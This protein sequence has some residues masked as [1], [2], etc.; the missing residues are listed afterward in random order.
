MPAAGTQEQLREAFARWGL[1]RRMRVDNGTPWG[2]T[3]ELPTE[4]ALWLIGLGVEMIWNPPR[5]PQ[6]NGVVERSQGTGKRWAEP[7]TCR[8]VAELRLRLEEQDDIQRALYPR[9]K[10]LSRMEA[11]PGLKH[12]GRAYRPD[13]EERA[14]D[15]E[16]VLSHLADYVLVRRVD[17]SGTVSVY[18]KSRYVGKALCGRDVY[19][20]LDPLA[21]EWTYSGP[22]GVCYRRQKAEELTAERVR[23]LNVSRHRQRDR[24]ARQNR[25]SGLEA[26]PIVA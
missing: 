15:L 10:G 8:D 12:S 4:L 24:K 17:G 23:G 1:P 19:I 9:F 26:E 2:S 16:P 13:E 11:F 6:A 14:W 20:T 21:V 7:G 22:D 18:N 5:R 25:L 3:G